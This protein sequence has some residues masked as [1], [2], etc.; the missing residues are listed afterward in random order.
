MPWEQEC[1]PVGCILH[2]AVA[3]SPSMHAP[4]TPA[5]HTTCHACPLPCTPPAMHAP[6]PR[7][8]PTMHTTCHACPLPCTPPAMHTTCHACPPATHTTYHA[9]HLSRM[10]W[11]IWKGLY[12]Y[13]NKKAV[14]LFLK[15]RNVVTFIVNRWLCYYHPQWSWGKVIFSEACVKNSV[16]GGCLPYCMLGYIPRGQRQTPPPQSRSPRADPLQEQTPP[17]SRHPLEQT[18]PTTA[19]AGI[20]STSG[21]YASYWNAY[22]F[23]HFVIQVGHG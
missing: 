21:W 12:V 3:I 9:H 6:L 18:S 10:P 5:M 15:K 23:C 7:T 20:W 13:I 22:L 2:A 16:H 4:T 19:H 17:G 11:G 1:I 14:W 8:P